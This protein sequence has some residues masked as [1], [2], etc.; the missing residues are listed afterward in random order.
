MPSGYSVYSFRGDLSYFTPG[1]NNQ[2]ASG[3]SIPRIASYIC[4]RHPATGTRKQTYPVVVHDCSTMKK[5]T[6]WILLATYLSA[7][8]AGLLPWVK[9]AAAHLF[10]Y[11]GH[12]HHVHHGHEDHAHVAAE[13]VQ[14]LSAEHGDSESFSEWT[15]VRISLPVH[16]FLN[17]V[18]EACQAVATLCVSFPPFRFL[19]PAGAGLS[20]FLP[21]E[22]A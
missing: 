19:L 4:Y 13:I 7:S 15:G 2:T 20:V 12:M 21:P 9:D 17:A 16:F 5:A 22:R 14:L 3:K 1:K 8:C 11:E 18:F 10:W 6:A